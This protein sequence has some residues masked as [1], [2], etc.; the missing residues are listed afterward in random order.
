MTVNIAFATEKYVIMASDKRMTN[1]KDTSEYYD[2]MH[3]TFKVNPNVYVS[4]SGD[5]NVST[6]CLYHLKGLDLQQATVQAV[7]TR[8]KRFLKQEYK[9]NPNIQQSIIVAGKGDGNKM[10]LSSVRHDGK[11]KKIVLKPNEYRY[12]TN[13]A[14]VPVIPL[15]E[16]QIKP[17]VEQGQIFNINAVGD[18]IG[19]VIKEVANKDTFVSPDYD[20]SYLIAD[21]LHCS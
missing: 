4:L 18:V 7:T 12:L 10:T 21:D 17:L 2:T 6:S 20:I 3:K 16:E 15:L 8:I 11:G 19:N 5:T 9:N 13:Y 1:T 14:N